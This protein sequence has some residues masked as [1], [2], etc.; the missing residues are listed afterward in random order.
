MIHIAAPAAD[1]WRVMVD[2]EGWPEWAPAMKRLELL[3]AA[4]MA[5]GSRVRIQPKRMPAAIWR[6]T[7]YEEERSF[8]WEASLAPGVRVQGGHLLAPDADGSTTEFWLEATGPLGTLV[9]PLL[10]RTI[11]SRNTRTATEGLK[12]HVEGGL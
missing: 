9:N 2:A 12:R 5:H 11:F 10:R 4:P 8:T 1:V 6:V 7:E 3:D